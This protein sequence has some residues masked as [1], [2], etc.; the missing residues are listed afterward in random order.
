MAP[1]YTMSLKNRVHIIHGQA[2]LQAVS[3]FAHYT[4]LDMHVTQQCCRRFL[5]T[6]ACLL[7]FLDYPGGE[8]ETAQSQTVTMEYMALQSSQVV[9][10]FSF[11]AHWWLFELSS[12]VVGKSRT[13][14]SSL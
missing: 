3:L 2:R 9:I 8:R 11:M 5:C 7:I 10:F 6:L 1:M 14:E 13:A 12:T 4:W